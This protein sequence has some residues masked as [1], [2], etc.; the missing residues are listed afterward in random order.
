MSPQDTSLPAREASRPLLTKTTSRAPNTARA[1][2]QRAIQDSLSCGAMCPSSPC[3]R[4]VRRPRAPGKKMR[5]TSI[6][7]ARVSPVVDLKNHLRR[8]PLP[9]QEGESDTSERL[10]WPR[11]QKRGCPLRPRTPKRGT[12]RHAV[13]VDI[14][15]ALDIK[16]SHRSPS[17]P[18]FSDPL[19]S[20]AL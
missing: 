15:I 19:W 8:A 2:R 7:L 1:T 13:H 17:P 11:E 6:D 4:C 10:P 9:L 14:G 16:R 20:S 3:I 12:A 18:A 5:A